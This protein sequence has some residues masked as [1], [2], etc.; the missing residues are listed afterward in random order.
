MRQF[1]F[2]KLDLEDK[3]LLCHIAEKHLPL[4]CQLCSDLFESLEDLQSIGN[5]KYTILKFI[6]KSQTIEY[7]II[8]ILLLLFFFYIIIIYFFFSFFFLL[9]LMTNNIHIHRY[10][11]VLPLLTSI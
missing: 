7:I 9:V 2:E 4:R 6:R 1:E 8:I 11:Y 5:Q 3:K 10:M